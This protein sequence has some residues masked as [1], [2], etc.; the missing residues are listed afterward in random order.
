VLSKAGTKQPPHDRP[1][2]ALKNLFVLIFDF[3][4]L[5]HPWNSRLLLGFGRG[6]SLLIFLEQIMVLP[7]ARP[8]VLAKGYQK[9]PQVT[10]EPCRIVVRFR[11]PSDELLDNQSVARWFEW[12]IKSAISFASSI[13]E[14]DS[15]VQISTQRLDV[16]EGSA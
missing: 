1:D 2:H 5:D 9:V 14:R 15:K 7:I 3:T 13:I 8:R 11:A 4:R 12:K 16:G 10:L 6:Q